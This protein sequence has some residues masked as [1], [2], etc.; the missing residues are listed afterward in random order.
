MEGTRKRHPAAFKARGALEAAKQTHNRP[1]E[2]RAGFP[3]VMYSLKSRVILAVIDLKFV[4]ASSHSPPTH[5]HRH[6]VGPVRR[7]QLPLRP[8]RICPGPARRLR[9]EW[10]GADRGDPEVVD[11]N[12]TRVGNSATREPDQDRRAEP[13]TSR[14]RTSPRV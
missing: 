3:E 2:P 4:I 7:G 11:L 6:L 10:A 12:A 1:A 13:G 5:H 9:R 8:G 14:A